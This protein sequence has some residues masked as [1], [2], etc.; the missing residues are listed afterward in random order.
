MKNFGP[1]GVVCSMLLLAGHK[2]A[3]FLKPHI[4]DLIRGHLNFL[5]AVEFSISQQSMTIKEIADRQTDH[6]EKLNQ[7]HDKVLR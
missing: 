1:V 2:I 6:G 4:E 3:I 5:K 7:I